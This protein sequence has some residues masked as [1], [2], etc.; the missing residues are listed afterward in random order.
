[1]GKKVPN[2]AKAKKSQGSISSVAVKGYTNNN[3]Q[4]S[5][6]L[7]MNMVAHWRELPSADQVDVDIQTVLREFTDYDLEAMNNALTLMS[8]H[9]SD[10]ATKMELLHEKRLRRVQFRAGQ[11]LPSGRRMSQ[12]PNGSRTSSKNATKND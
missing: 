3:L 7:L 11:N 10:D 8:Y 1:M 4:E 5:A 9:F 2:M 12:T 6:D